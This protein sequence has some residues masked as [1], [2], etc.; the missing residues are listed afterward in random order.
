MIIPDPHGA[1]VRMGLGLEG[2]GVRVVTAARPTSESHPV[3]CSRPA[4]GCQSACHAID[5][6]IPS[7]RVHELAILWPF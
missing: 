3:D 6:C 5:Q 2:G 4:A 1:W 7:K